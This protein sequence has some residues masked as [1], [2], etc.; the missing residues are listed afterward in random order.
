MSVVPCVF[1]G[2]NLIR[3]VDVF[4]LLYSFYFILIH[5]TIESMIHPERIA[6]LNAAP[7]RPGRYV[8]YWM[9]QSQRAHCNHALEYAVRMADDMG[10]PVLVG[11]G[12][13]PDYP[14][15]NR[16][17]FTF[18]LEGLKET[19]RQ[20]QSRGIGFVVRR[21]SPPEAALVLAREA[22]L[23]VCDRGYL[24]H[25]RE[26]RQSVARRAHCRVV[27]VE[28]DVVVPL[29]VVSDKAE[30]AARTLR[31]KIHR[32]L[33]TFLVPLKEKKPRIAWR[34]LHNQAGKDM[35][36]SEGL[37][38]SLGL[39]RR[40]DA[41]SS[42]FQGGRSHALLRFREFADHGLGSYQ[43]ISRLPEQDA[44]SHM[45]PWLHFGQVSPL[46]LAFMVRKLTGEGREAWLEQLVVR[47]ELA[48]NF[49][50]FHPSY[51]AYACV[52]QWA[53][54]SLADRGEDRRDR[55]T[56]RQLEAAETEDPYWNAAMREMRVTG[57]MHTYM[58]M[59]WGKKILEWIPEPEAAFLSIRE[60]NNRWFLDGRDPNSYAG[61]AWIFGVHDRAWPQRPGFG[62]V[63]SMTARGLERKCDISAYVRRVQA[64]ARG[65]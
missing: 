23:L 12:L 55:Y 13:D 1:N 59:Y 4:F 11:F 21:D 34:K 38:D 25:Q 44:T 63:R 20:L 51:D 64:A 54:K 56:L 46:E 39:D 57:F 15:A 29:E 7:V 49:T 52:P 35:F 16:R 14:E 36:H 58:R 3:G 47:R 61:V 42:F 60:L 62:K 43:E 28:S 48:A 10:L 53:R 41:V 65:V 2:F 33:K 37:L 5:A 22:A 9:Q 18:M 17:H 40:V 6:D 30:Y 31:P 45:S 19:A 32:Y 8:L 50:H 26:W 24:R 27:R